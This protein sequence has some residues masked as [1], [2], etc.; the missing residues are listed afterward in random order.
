M[1]VENIGDNRLD[2]LGSYTEAR[3]YLILNV[4]EGHIGKP[5]DVIHEVNEVLTAR[6][7]ELS[8]SQR[9]T[10]RVDEVQGTG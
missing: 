6:I 3:A 2:H 7:G 9:E 5:V 4:V 8:Y 1:T 10:S